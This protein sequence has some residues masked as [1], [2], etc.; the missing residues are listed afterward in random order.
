MNDA[1]ANHKEDKRFAN[2]ANV[3]YAAEISEPVSQS[4]ETIFE[5]RQP[6]MNK[7]FPHVE[8]VEPSGSMAQR[9]VFGGR[10]E[11]HRVIL[12]SRDQWAEKI[13]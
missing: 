13:R 4:P 6:H 10:E 12:W 5:K 11:T 3:I 1:M 8:D 2:D 7:V 9:L